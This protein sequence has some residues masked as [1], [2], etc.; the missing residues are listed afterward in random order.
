MSFAPSAKERIAAGRRWLAKASHPLSAIRHPLLLSA[1]ASATVL[2][3]PAA[4]FTASLDRDT[5]TLGESAT[6]SLTF[7]GGQPREVPSLPA[8]QNL[9]INYLGPSSQFSFV[10]GQVSSTVTH[11]FT[12]T[13]RQAGEFTIPAVTA[14]VGGQKLTTQPVTL[15]VLRPGAPSPEAIQSGAQLAFARLLLPKKE[16]YLGEVITAELQIYYRQGLQ[17]AREP[18]LIG[19]PA[20]GLT[21]GKFVGG[22]SRQVQMGNAVYGVVT[23]TASLTA[24]RVGA[25]TLGP[26]TLNTLVLLPSSG[27]RRGS[28]FDDMPDPFGMF[29][30]RE[31]RQLSLATDPV[32]IQSLPLP[33]DHVPPNFNGAVGSYTL[34]VTAGPTNV[35]T[36]DPITVRVRIAGR[37][38][39]DALRLPEQPAW[40]DFKTYAPTAK[41]ETS[42]Q[43]GIQGAKTFE[44][45]V[46][47]EN[48]DVKELPAF[49]FSFFDP[50][51][52]AYRTLTQPPIQLAVRSGGATVVPVLASKN[53]TPETPPPAQDIVPIKQRLGA[54]A[55]IAPP[56]V[57]QPWFLALQGAPVLAWFVALMW[58]KRSDWLANNPRVRRQRQVAHLIRSGLADLRRLAKENKSDEFFATLFRL[59]QEQLGERL[60]C[61]ASAITEAV[62]EERLRPRGVTDDVLAPLHDLFQACNLARYAPVR[63]TQELEAVIPKLEV[64]LRELQMLT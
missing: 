2:G 21:V 56:L 31:Q 8:V 9:E 45:I 13:P 5:I 44:Q 17:P 12:V 19:L 62:I 41:V 22:Q 53:S 28:L 14:V 54:V 39:L 29:D 6:L 18:Q 33:T 26:V 32:T 47:P 38:A 49:S 55:Q 3:A 51:Q 24:L 46:S 15:K 59:L 25:L 42:D 58:R 43:L 11:M 27:N 64:M 52:K 34:T 40:H 36:G 1:L 57:Q 4:T 20:D 61:P 63:T 10:N 48:T 23:Y 37:G 7:N 16:V 50:D 35:A 60:D 30:R